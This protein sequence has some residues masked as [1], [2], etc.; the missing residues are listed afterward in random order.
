M[1]SPAI[2]VEPSCPLAEPAELMI[3]HDVKGLAVI[4]DDMLVGILT[5]FDLARHGLRCHGRVSTPASSPLAVTT[6][7][8]LRS[9]SRVPA[10]PESSRPRPHGQGFR[11]GGVLDLLGPLLPTDLS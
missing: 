6:G 11:D 5:R 8:T 3:E 9:A 1:S 2:T 7:S 10:L 4:E